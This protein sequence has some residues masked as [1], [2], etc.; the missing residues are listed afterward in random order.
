[1]KA[2][3]AAQQELVLIDA[4]RHRADA[5][6]FR[7]SQ[8]T[9]RTFGGYAVGDLE[10]AIALLSHESVAESPDTLRAAARLTDLASDRVEIVAVPPL[11]RFLARKGRALAWFDESC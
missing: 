8:P 11:P 7:A 2:P 4:L 3:S 1:M 5:L 6:L 9:L 10:Q